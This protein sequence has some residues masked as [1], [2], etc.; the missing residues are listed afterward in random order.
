MLH[1]FQWF[2]FYCSSWLISACLSSCTS[3]PY[4]TLG[5]T[6]VDHSFPLPLCFKPF[7]LWKLAPISEYAV[8]LAKL[9]LSWMIGLWLVSLSMPRCFVWFSCWTFSLSMVY[10]KSPGFFG[11]KRVSQ[12]TTL[13]WLDAVSIPSWITVATVKHELHLQLWVRQKA[14]SSATVT[15]GVL[16]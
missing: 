15:W 7:I 16:I 4:K 13:S 3:R 6:Y 5:V 10:L 11:K 9:I 8:L 14:S 1:L 2:P 12:K